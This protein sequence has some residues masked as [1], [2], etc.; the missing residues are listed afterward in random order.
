MKKQIVV[1][2]SLSDQIKDSKRVE[3]KLHQDLPR[4]SVIPDKKKYD[5][6]SEKKK[7]KDWEK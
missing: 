2:K 6:K 1:Q 4:P 7:C 5:R 3:R